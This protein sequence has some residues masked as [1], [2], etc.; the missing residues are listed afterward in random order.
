MPL[1]AGNG[2]RVLV[3]SQPELVPLFTFL[4]CALAGGTAFATYKVNESLFTRNK[5]QLKPWEKTSQVT[6]TYG[7]DATGYWLNR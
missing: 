2:L 7:K 6:D 1:F 4:S 3:K 5:T